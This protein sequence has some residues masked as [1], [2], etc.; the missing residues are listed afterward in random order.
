MI[1]STTI[2]RWFAAGALASVLG[3]APAATGAPPNAEAPFLAENQAAMGRMMAAMEIKPTG[4]VDR[5]FVAM[6]IPHHP[7]A[8][9]MARAEL[10]YGHNQ[11]LRRMSQE[12]MATQGEE[13]V[14]MRRAIGEP[15]TAAPRPMPPGMQMR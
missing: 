6:M 2:Y 15:A 10:R 7:G 4:D 14:A 8:I 5:D 9:E 3:L 1:R 12:I 11:T 13:I